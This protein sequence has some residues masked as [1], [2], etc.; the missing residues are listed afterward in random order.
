MSCRAQTGVD[1][2]STKGK[3]DL[4]VVAGKGDDGLFFVRRL[5]RLVPILLVRA[6]ELDIFVEII[7]ICD[8]YEKS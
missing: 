3:M 6:C 1:W 2:V 8:K 7:I 5:D 4:P